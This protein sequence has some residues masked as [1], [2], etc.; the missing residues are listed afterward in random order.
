MPPVRLI[1]I[2]HGQVAGNILSQA[3][4]N[5]WTECPLSP[6]GRRQARALRHRMAVEPPAAALYSSPLRRAVETARAFDGLPLGPLRLLPELREM[7]CGEIDGLPAL[8]AQQRY[9]HLWE[10]NQR[11]EDEDLHWPGGETYREFRQ[12]C[13]TGLRR[14]VQ[15]HPGER[16]VVVTHAGVISQ[17]LGAIH[18]LHSAQWGFFRPGNASLTEIEWGLGGGVLL[19]FDDRSHLEGLEG[20]EP[21]AAESCRNVVPVGNL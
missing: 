7:Y 12:R 13:L 3:R 18:G 19:R 2:R 8:E 1:L 5:G 20:D 4:V 16:V 9:P 21:E 10:I 6:L 14:I 17:I 11:Q 15:T